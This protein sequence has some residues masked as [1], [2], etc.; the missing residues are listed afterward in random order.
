MNGK[1]DTSREISVPME[2]V[3]RIAL[4]MLPVIFLLYA[5]PFLIFWF[6]P[7]MNSIPEFFRSVFSEGGFHVLWPYLIKGITALVAGIVLHELLH[8]LG[9]LPFTKR[10]LRSFRFGIKMP[11][12]APYAH[13][14]ESLPVNGYRTGILLPGIVLG[15]APAI[16]GI[17]KGNFLWLCF[18][19]FFTWAASGDMIMFWRI[20]KFKSQTLVMDH[21]QKLGCFITGNIENR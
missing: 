11:E 4:I 20:R 18:G 12:M 5:V 9:W 2:E 21:P 17:I 19:M 3:Y 16:Y 7:F 15:L 8:A 13:C 14:T 1:T 6:R 10:G